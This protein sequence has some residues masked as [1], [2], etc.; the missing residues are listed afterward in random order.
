MP[1]LNIR[2]LDEENNPIPGEKVTIFI[3]HM[4]SPQTW[5]KD[6]TDDDGRVYFDFDGGVSADVH[7]RGNCELKSVELNGEVTVSV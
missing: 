7:V 5:L 4:L 1:Y 6:Y 3:S 2:V